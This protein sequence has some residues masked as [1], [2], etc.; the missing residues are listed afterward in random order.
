MSSS[1]VDQ[2]GDRYFRQRKQ[3]IKKLDASEENVI[4]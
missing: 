4:R 2:G 3:H 1:L